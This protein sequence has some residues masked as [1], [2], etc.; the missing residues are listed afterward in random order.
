MWSL[1]QGFFSLSSPRV[2]LRYS[3]FQKL[4]LWALA[5]YLLFWATISNF[6]YCFCVFQ[7]AIWYLSFIQ[8][9][10]DHFSWFTTGFTGTQVVCSSVFVL[11]HASTFLAVLHLLKLHLFSS[12]FLFFLVV[13]WIETAASKIWSVFVLCF[14]SIVFGSQVVKQ[15]RQFSQLS[16][17]VIVCQWFSQT[18]FIYFYILE[19]PF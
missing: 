18:G 19:Q 4:S 8:F 9:P 11:R 16:I 3:V 17:Y 6:F 10:W 2:L 15:V 5:L 14:Q 12:L 13:F 7:C 1:C